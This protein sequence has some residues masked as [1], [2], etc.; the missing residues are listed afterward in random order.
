MRSHQG[1]GPRRTR[2]FLTVFLS[3]FVPHSLPPLALT[4]CRLDFIMKHRYPEGSIGVD[5]PYNPT[6]EVHAEKRIAREKREVKIKKVF[7]VPLA[8][9]PPG[10]LPPVS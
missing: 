2:R 3:L 9:Q 6:S 1:N 5:S 7:I 10:L 4:R 8:R